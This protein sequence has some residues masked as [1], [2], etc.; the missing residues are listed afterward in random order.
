MLHQVFLFED[1]ENTLEVS[2]AAY[3]SHSLS[4]NR[5]KDNILKAFEN[6][7]LKRKSELKKAE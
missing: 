5:N 4:L 2:P 3:G 6:K 1:D 7:M